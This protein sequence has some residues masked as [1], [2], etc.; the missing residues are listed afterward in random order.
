MRPPKL[1]YLEARLSVR[2]RWWALSRS[3][4]RACAWTFLA[5]AA[6]AM[7]KLPS[8]AVTEAGRRRLTVIAFLDVAGYS[9][10]MGADE[11]QTHYQWLAGT[12]ATDRAVAA[13]LAWQDRR[14][15]RRWPAD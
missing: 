14:S 10:M 4:R 3:L 6:G 7:F 2:S 5:K 11:H 12:G 8:K 9:R 1:L 13:G 15:R